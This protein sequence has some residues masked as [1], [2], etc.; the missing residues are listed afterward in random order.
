MH[1][2]RL[3]AA[4]VLAAMSQIASAQAVGPKTPRSVTSEWR[5]VRDTHG[6]EVRRELVNR[7]F[8]FAFRYIRTKPTDLLF[9]QEIRTVQKRSE[10]GDNGR[11]HLEAWAS[12]RP[13]TGFQNRLWIADLPGSAARLLSDYYETTESGCCGTFD[14]RTL[15]SLET[16]RPVA[17]FTTGPVSIRGGAVG[18]PRVQRP[19]SVLYLSSMGT[20]TVG[21]SLA[22][23]LAF[24][25]LLLVEGDSVLSRVILRATRADA[26]PLASVE[27]A[28]QSDPD[29]VSEGALFL[30]TG[31]RPA[32]HIYSDAWR[33][34]L[35][36]LNGRGFTL[37]GATIPGG[38][39][40]EL[41]KPN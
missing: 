20:H 34:I 9:A 3:I 18:E 19:L 16:G 37:A 13:D 2:Y 4:A 28:F 39:K 5:I 8:E 25:E 15:L 29:S 36:P 22:D 38:V 32:A 40:A 23:S 41:V 27:F 17:S 14:T 30:R 6:R 1:A 26:D 21:R 35:I 12:T 7:T 31:S 24:G 10:E 33:P 11:V